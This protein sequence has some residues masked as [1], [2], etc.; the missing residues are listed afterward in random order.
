MNDEAEKLNDYALRIVALL[1]AAL[2][3]D[4]DGYEALNPPG[5]SN[6]EL[7]DALVGY[8]LAS[9]AITANSWGI[10]LPQYI[11]SLQAT[12]IATGAQWFRDNPS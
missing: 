12:T 9:V 7:V 3:G 1:K 4:K 11:D 5:E 10:P 8:L 2:A 6:S